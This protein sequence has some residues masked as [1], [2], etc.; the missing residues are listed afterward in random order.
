MG[1]KRSTDVVIKMKIHL[2]STAMKESSIAEQCMDA[3]YL[4]K[5]CSCLKGGQCMAELGKMDMPDQ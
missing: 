3:D 1:G 2:K 5:I 4:V